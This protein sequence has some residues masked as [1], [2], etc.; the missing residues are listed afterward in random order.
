MSCTFELIINILNYAIKNKEKAFSQKEFKNIVYTEEF[1]NYDINEKIAEGFEY[2]LKRGFLEL[3]TKNTNY[4]EKYRLSETIKIAT[5]Y[6]KD[7]SKRI[8]LLHEGKEMS[9]DTYEV[10]DDYA[11]IIDSVNITNSG[12]LKKRDK[13]EIKA[14]LS[15]ILISLNV[16]SNANYSLLTIIQLLQLKSQIKIKIRT[17]NCEFEASNIMLHHIQFNKD[18]ILLSFDKCSFEIDNIENILHIDSM[19]SLSLKEHI[20][21][22]LS[23]LKSYKNEN[24]EFLENFL[25]QYSTEE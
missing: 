22:S 17:D 2:L 21:N 18:T 24:I 15:K 13:D 20:E 12:I 4:Y 10:K 16:E 23:L 5:E 6:N 1:N 7:L 3:K 25:R 19:D 8:I 9:N 11:D 14:T